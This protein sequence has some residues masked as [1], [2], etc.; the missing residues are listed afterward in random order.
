[1]PGTNKG[2]NKM[3]LVI[4]FNFLPNSSQGIPTLSLSLFKFFRQRTKG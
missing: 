1:M 4:S 2:K 3:K